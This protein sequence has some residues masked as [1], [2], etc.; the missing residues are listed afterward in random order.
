MVKMFS[1]APVPANHR[2]P[3][4][5]PRFMICSSFVGGMATAHHALALDKNRSVETD[6]R[7]TLPSSPL[8]FNFQF[9]SFADRRCDP[10]LESFSATLRK[11][12]SLRCVAG[13]LLLFFAAAASLPLSL[14]Y[15]SS[16]CT[17]A[18]GLTVHFLALPRP[19]HGNRSIHA[20]LPLSETVEFCDSPPRR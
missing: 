20:A 2:P 11:H 8:S 19:L 16:H 5:L 7:S 17:L 4:T 3:T 9:S 12:C 6:R 14:A 18:D 10:C 15:T 13:Y 1:P